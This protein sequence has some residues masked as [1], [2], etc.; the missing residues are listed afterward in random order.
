MRTV[1]RLA[2]DAGCWDAYDWITRSYLH[3][4]AALADGI[5]GIN[6]MREMLP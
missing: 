2:R 4:R 3:P 6:E 5:I 1:L